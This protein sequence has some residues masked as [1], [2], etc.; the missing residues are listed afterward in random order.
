[1]KPRFFHNLAL[2]AM[3]LAGCASVSY[4]DM[5]DAEFSAAFV[6]QIKIVSDESAPKDRA[7]DEI[8]LLSAQSEL[9]DMGIRAVPKLLPAFE[10]ARPELKTNLVPVLG[11]IG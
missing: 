2:A 5:A 1:L 3:L 9:A 11:Q 8:A 10:T 7:P 4:I 6:R